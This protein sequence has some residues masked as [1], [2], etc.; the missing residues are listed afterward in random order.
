MQGDLHCHTRFS[1]G[2]M[3]VNSL[4]DYA[5]RLG[6]NAIAVTDH[7]T[8]AGALGAAAYA[9]SRGVSLLPGME[10]STFSRKI[11]RKVHLLC[12]LPHNPQPLLE[13]CGKTLRERTRCSE[14]AVEMLS[15]RYPI[16]FETVRRYAAGCPAVYRQHIML[17]LCD[18]GYSLTIFGELYREL[19]SSHGGWALVESRYP[20]TAE[21]LAIIKECGGLAVLAHPGV[22][23][24]FPLIP[25]LC[26]MGLD[27]IEAFHPRQTKEDEEKA[28]AAAGKYGLFITGGS[29]FHGYF[30]MSLNQPGSRTAPESTLAYF[31]SLNK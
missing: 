18:M 3:E 21:A 8:M 4:I 2:S 31:T 7:D 6:L 19:F 23:G 27:G 9:S 11:G 29:D 5:V 24:S 14:K 13:L 20:E 22:Y 12:Y 30:S 15:K 28:V 17:A 16:D 10:V 25:E 1:D 26:R